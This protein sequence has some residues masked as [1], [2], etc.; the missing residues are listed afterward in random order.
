MANIAL[1]ECCVCFGKATIRTAFG[2]GL[3]PKVFWVECECGTRTPICDSPDQAI[4]IWNWL[5]RETMSEEKR[6]KVKQDWIEQQ[7]LKIEEEENK[8]KKTIV[9]NPIEKH[10]KTVNSKASNKVVKVNDKVEVKKKRHRRTKA[11]M[12]AA[13][14]AGLK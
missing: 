4:K 14:A 12:I 1:K 13:R 7:R 9:I 8:R 11:E 2:M 10:K 6:N 3:Q 5:H